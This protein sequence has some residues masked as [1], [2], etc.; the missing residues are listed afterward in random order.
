MRCGPDWSYTACSA[1]CVKTRDR[2]FCQTTKPLA[3]NVSGPGL[4]LPRSLLRQHCR[5]SDARPGSS[6]LCTETR[7][8]PDAT[9]SATLVSSRH[10]GV[11]WAAFTRPACCCA[12]GFVRGSCT[13]WPSRLYS[14]G[15]PGVTAPRRTRTTTKETGRSN[16]GDN[17]V[18]AYLNFQFP[19][20]VSARLRGPRTEDGRCR[21][22][23]HANAFDG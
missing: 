13:S 2:R 14:R 1:M 5:W 12:W 18:P 15:L 7:Q 11:L 22:H 9:V 19:P 23:T 10:P 3:R 20:E 8:G 16:L 6:R 17:S 4:A 21:D